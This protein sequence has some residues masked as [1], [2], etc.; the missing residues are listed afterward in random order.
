VRHNGRILCARVAPV[1]VHL[2]RRPLTVLLNQP[3]MI[4]DECAGVGR[5]RV[6]RENRSTRR[7]LAPVPLRP[8][9]TP[10]DLTWAR[11]RAAA[12]VSRRLTS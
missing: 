11:T 2:V 10:H 5:M 12:V 6:G 4:D 7:K 3:R 9:Q 8:P 1:L